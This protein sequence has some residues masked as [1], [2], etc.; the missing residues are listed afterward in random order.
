MGS[1]VKRKSPPLEWAPAR[2]VRCS[3]RDSTA[4][5]LRLDLGGYGRQYETL[6]GRPVDNDAVLFLNLCP[7]CKA[8]AVRSGCTEY[9]V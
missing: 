6:C 8:A 3:V 1:F 9:D 5:H 4:Y 2:R 7:Q